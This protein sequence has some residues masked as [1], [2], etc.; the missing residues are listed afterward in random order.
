VIETWI[1][2]RH[3]FAINPRRLGEVRAQLDLLWS[4]AL[5][6]FARHVESEGAKTP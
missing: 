5:A 3:Y 6:A 1:G 4:D 2:T